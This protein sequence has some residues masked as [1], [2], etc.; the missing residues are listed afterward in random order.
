MAVEVFTNQAS[1]TVSAGGTTAPSPGTTETWTVASSSSFPAISGS[2]QFHVADPATTTTAAEIIAVTAVS[3]TSWT[4]TRGAESTTPVAHTTGFTV[5]QVITAASLSTFAQ[6]G[7]GD[8]GGSGTAATVAKIQGT[9]IAVPSGGTAAFLNATGAWSAPSVQSVTFTYGTTG[10]VPSS[11]TFTAGAVAVDQNNTLRVCIT[12]GTPGVWRRAGSRSFQFYLDDYGAKGDGTQALVNTTSGS[13]IITATP[14]AA[15]SAPTVSNSGSGGTIAAGTY[16]VEVTYVNRW[17]ETVA[18]ASA[19]TTTTGTT[20]TITITAPASKGN[21]TGWYAYVTQAGGSTY[22]RQQGAGSPTPSQQNLILTAPPTSSGANPPGADSSAAQVF[23][24]TGVDGGKNVIICGGLGSPGAPWI[25]TI[26]SVQ[27]STQA[28]LS[29]NGASQGGNVTQAG[30]AM[31]FSTDDRLAIDACIQAAQ[32]YILTSGDNTIQIIGSDKVYGLGSNVFQST[33]ATGALQYNTQVRIPVPWSSNQAPKVEFQLTG[34]GDNSHCTF[35]VSQLPNLMGT[36]F[37]SYTL[38]PTSADPTFGQ[39]SVIGAPTGGVNNNGSNSFANVKAVIDGIQVV[40]PGWSNTIG[41]DFVTLGGCRLRG[42]SQPYAPSANNGG[43]VNPSNAWVANSFWQNKI[44]A[45][46]R[47]P[48]ALN[49][50]DCIIDSFAVEGLKSGVLTQ[51]DHINFGALKTINCYYGV[52][53]TGTG[54]GNHDLTIKNWTAEGLV[55]AL[56]CPSGGAG[57]IMCNITLDSETASQIDVQDNGNTFYGVLYWDDPFRSPAIPTVQGAANLK[58]INCQLGPG[59]W[60][61]A[62]AAPG[63]TV[64]QQNTAYRDAT[65][66][67]SNTTAAVTAIAVGPTSS[68]TTTTGLVTTTSLPAAVRVPA[69][70]W[71]KATYASGTLVTAW[72]LD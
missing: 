39:Q 27:S 33:D 43:G 63:T 69:G 67:L 22:T 13:A 4:V 46:M 24:S 10:A 26:L 37:L 5:Q 44:S 11:G 3:G 71:Y 35:W 45:G 2:Q 55:A 17:G 32:A 18:S 23:T 64:A 36:T 28:T 20:S 57:H 54:S 51:A 42:S 65:I 12:S 30:C 58:I 29:T 47:V 60:S 7:T 34:P 61:G 41:F 68:T 6:A 15:P 56:S 31:A 25:D 59:T 62:P 40:Q 9:T 70:S 52:N 1:T 49:N 21:A 48:N 50:A 8:L 16:Q 14:L 72:F 53:V 38:G 66:I 19:S